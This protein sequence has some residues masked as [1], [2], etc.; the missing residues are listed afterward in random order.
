MESRWDPKGVSPGMLF[1]TSCSGGCSSAAI[2]STQQAPEAETVSDAVKLSYFFALG[3]EFSLN[4]V[5]TEAS[6]REL[7]LFIL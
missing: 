4:L 5:N 3:S 7:Y 1:V 2:F 6:H